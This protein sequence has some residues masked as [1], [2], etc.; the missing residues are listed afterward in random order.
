MWCSIYRGHWLQ[1]LQN[2]WCLVS[3]LL[4]IL[5]IARAS[6][7]AYTQMQG[8][9]DFLYTLVVYFLFYELL[10]LITMRG[11][12]AFPQSWYNF[13]Y[14]YFSCVFYFLW[15]VF[16]DNYVWKNFLSTIWTYWRGHQSPRFVNT[17]YFVSH[18][19]NY[20]ELLPFFSYYT[21]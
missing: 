3:R 11:K 9:I 16:F 2:F 5:W 21:C 15:D 4:L 7:L 6:N 1:V 17:L 20:H 19:L 13:F 10:S 12:Y 8:I 14:L 18:F